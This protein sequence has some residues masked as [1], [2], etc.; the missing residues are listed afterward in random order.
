M[1]LP[2]RVRTD[3]LLINP[4][5]KKKKNGVHLRPK[6]LHYNMSIYTHTTCVHTGTLT[7]LPAMCLLLAPFRSCIGLL[8]GHCPSQFNQ[9]VD[10][11]SLTVQRTRSLNT[12]KTGSGS[13]SQNPSQCRSSKIPRHFLCRIV[14]S[15]CPSD[16]QMCA[17]LC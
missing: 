4:L 1:E 9:C 10:Y 15:L 14:A 7:H 17:R 12:G 2:C 5:T 8:V 16:C 11:C 6:Q 13:K 3:F